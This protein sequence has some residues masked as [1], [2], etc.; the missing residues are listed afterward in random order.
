MRHFVAI[1]FLAAVC[2]PVAQG[3]RLSGRFLTSFYTWERFDTVG[4]SKNYLRAYQGMQLQFVHKNFSLHTYVQGTTNFGNT[5]S[6][7]PSVRF[8]NLYG[9]LKNIGNVGE[10]QVGRVPVY[11]GV[12][13]GSIDGIVGKLR[14]WNGKVRLKG[15]GGGN[16]PDRQK[17]K[18]HSDIGNNFA[19]G[20]QLVSR[21]IDDFSIGV[22]YLKRRGKPEVYTALRPDPQFNSVAVEIENTPRVDEFVSGDAQYRWR[23]RVTT[24][25]RYDYDLK[26]DRT[27]RAQ[28]SLRATITDRLSVTGDYVYRAPRIPFNSFFSVFTHGTVREWEGGVEYAFSPV[29]RAFTRIATL[30]YSDTNSTRWTIGANTRYA[31]ASYSFNNGY[32]GELNSVTAQVVYPLN[33]HKIMPSGAVSYS[34]YRLHESQ[35][36]TDDAWSGLVG[37]TLRLVRSFSFDLQGQWLK[38]K[39]MDNDLRLL[40]KFTFW[41]SERVNIF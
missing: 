37:V 25:A 41:F 21:P 39:I 17:A 9:R 28:G 3:Q 29:V 40:G 7:D 6:T 1:I 2:T 30:R 12:G 26:L 38:N 16:V 19:W 23:G 34:R 14:L 31:S 33:N 13:N 11:A 35:S 4:V 5:F 27:Y 22:S 20:G 8:Y 10:I 15:Y 18:L 36:S 32:A 24:Y